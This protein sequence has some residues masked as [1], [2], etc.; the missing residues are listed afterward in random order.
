MLR[1]GKLA[2]CES[3]VRLLLLLKI[4]HFSA[5]V[6]LYL[7]HCNQALIVRTSHKLEQFKIIDACHGQWLIRLI[8]LLYHILDLVDVALRLGLLS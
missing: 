2:L 7:F 6:K 1:K 8:Y 3:L 5:N 4:L